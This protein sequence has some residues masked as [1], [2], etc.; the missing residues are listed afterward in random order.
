MASRVSTSGGWMSVRS[1]H[2]N[3]LR[4]RS[5]REERFA[6]MAIGAD[7]HLFAGFVEAVERVEELLEDLLLAFEELDVVEEEDVDVR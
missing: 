6:G 2:S 5:S 3:R 4:S 1:P 7:H